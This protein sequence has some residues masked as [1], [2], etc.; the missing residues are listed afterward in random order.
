MKH[1]TEYLSEAPTRDPDTPE[2]PQG[3][4]TVDDEIMKLRLTPEEKE[5]CLSKYQVQRKCDVKIWL[6][7]SVNT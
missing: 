6:K 7:A 1:Y 2:K 5:S 4:R 3:E